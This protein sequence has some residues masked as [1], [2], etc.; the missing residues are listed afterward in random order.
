LTGHRYH[1]IPWNKWFVSELQ[2]CLAESAHDVQMVLDYLTSREDLDMDRVGLYGQLSGAT[3]GILAAGVDPRIKVVDTLDPWGDWSTWMAESSF[4][5]PAER[6]DYLKPEFLAKVASLEPIDWMSKIQARK[7]RLQ[8]RSFEHETPLASKE[9]L[10]AAAPASATVAFYKTPDEFSD[11]VG[12]NTAKSLDWIKE[13]LM[14][15]PHGEPTKAPT[16]N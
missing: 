4:V 10:R 5:P 3:V 8:E 12:P 6:A 9:K 7:F 15:M 11:A 2:Q 14:S 16:R 13:Q 1:D